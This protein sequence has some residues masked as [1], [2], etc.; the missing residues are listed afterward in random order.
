MDNLQKGISTILKKCLG[1]KKKDLVLIIA[2]SK[3]K[4]IGNLILENS[5][6]ISKK[7]KLII[8]PL[9]KRHG[10]EPSKKVAKE[11]LKYD[12]ILIP[13]TKS[14]SHTKARRNASK[15]GARIASMPG[16]TEDMIK[17]AVDVD[18]KKMY[19]KIKKISNILDKGKEVE[20]KTKKGT[21]LHL[22]IKGRKTML[23]DVG[24]LTKR[25]SWGNLP[26]GEVCLAPLE[27]K[28]EGKLII[29]GSIGGIGGVK[30]RVVIEISKGHA[31]EIKGKTEARK[32][33]KM[34][35]AAGRK[36]FCVGELGIGMNDKAKLTGHVLEDEKVYGTFHVAFGNSLSFGG[37]INVPIHIDCVVK[38]PD[39][40]VDN[41]KIINKG[42][43]LV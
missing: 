26:S 41:K 24:L 43:L 40:W 23:S 21:N 38:S 30:N 2:D 29:D 35:S 27:G 34:L 7:S 1:V 18:Y 9:G 15:K 14:L 39:I 25:C 31:E 6:K 19:K 5:K 36:A 28:T 4:R 17:R 10:Q 12:V 42:K 8:I 33:K 32:L 22:K 11:M 16:I 13:T 3:T 37:K 20:I